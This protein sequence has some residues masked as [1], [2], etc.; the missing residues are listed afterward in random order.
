MGIWLSCL[1]A[2]TV[3]DFQNEM[4][5]LRIVSPGGGT[6]ARALQC[7]TAPV[8]LQQSPTLQF[9]K[10]ASGVPKQST[11]GQST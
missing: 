4:Y 5:M 6:S 2:Q 9:K 11:T 3:F 1:S 7:A 10:P 8:P